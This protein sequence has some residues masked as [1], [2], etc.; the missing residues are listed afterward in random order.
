MSQYTVYGRVSCPYTRGALDA[1]KD[2]KKKVKF[3]E[4]NAEQ[5]K[6]VVPRGMS[7]TVPQIYCDGQYVGGYS[8]L[9]DYWLPL[10]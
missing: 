1:L 9:V 5:L 3:F 10:H 2:R 7:L 8:D 4:V 6:G